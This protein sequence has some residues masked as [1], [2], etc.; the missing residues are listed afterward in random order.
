MWR[1]FQVSNITETHLGIHD[2]EGGF[3]GE[4]EGWGTSE[5]QC[6]VVWKYLGNRYG[7]YPFLKSKRGNRR[8]RGEMLAQA[9]MVA[10]WCAPLWKK[11]R[12]KV[13]YGRLQDGPDSKALREIRGLNDTSWNMSHASASENMQGEPWTY[14][15]ADRRQALD[16]ILLS[17]FLFD[18]VTSATVIRFDD[19]VSDHD[20]LAVDVQIGP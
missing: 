2:V 6:A 17:K 16:H 20:A 11:E 18:E 15:F 8:F 3:D 7:L 13:A 14:V 9:R 19:D 1:S 5:I 12:P 4:K 10:A